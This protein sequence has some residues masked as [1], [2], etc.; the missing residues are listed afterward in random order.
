MSMQYQNQLL[1]QENEELK[2]ENQLLRKEFKK[3]DDYVNLLKWAGTIT[4]II[5]TLFN[6]FGLYPTGPIMLWTGGV[7]WLIVSISWREYSLITVNIVMTIA[8]A[9]G[10]LYY[11][12]WS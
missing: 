6:S 2:R 5:G 11:F 10:L 4:L 8:G 3:A 1:Y 7:F 9:A 12:L